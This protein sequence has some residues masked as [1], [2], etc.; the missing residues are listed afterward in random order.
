MS[1]P[2]KEDSRWIWRKVGSITESESEL[3]EVGNKASQHRK[4]VI[5]QSIIHKIYIE[6]GICHKTEH[7][8]KHQ[9]KFYR[10]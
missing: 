6:L 10:T 5:I 2:L 7:F 4:Q 1:L 9:T 3:L 8:N